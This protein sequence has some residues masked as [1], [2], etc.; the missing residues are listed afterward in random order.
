MVDAI[1]HHI[2]ATSIP[3]LDAAIETARQHGASA[4]W[5]QSLDNR[6]GPLGDP[7]RCLHPS[8]K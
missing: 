3:T 2:L 5:Q 6:G 4:I 7:F 8:E 1:T